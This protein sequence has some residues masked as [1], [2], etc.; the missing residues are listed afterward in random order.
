MNTIF[1]N[2]INSKT[3]DPHRM[4]LNLSD[5][6]DLESSNKLFALSSFTIQGKIRK[7]RQN[8]KFKIPAPTWNKEFERSK[9]SYSVS[10]IQDYFEYIVTKHQKRMIILQ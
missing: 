10:D 4:L 3:S 7:V 8:I 1:M 5:K 6:I 9:V 2:F